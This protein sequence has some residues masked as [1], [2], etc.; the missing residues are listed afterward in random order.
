[1]NSN[2]IGK[3]TKNAMFKTVMVQWKIDI[4]EGFQLRKPSIKGAGPNNH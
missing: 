2:V 4:K 1:M 3:S